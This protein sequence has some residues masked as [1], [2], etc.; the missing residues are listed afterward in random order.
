MINGLT[1]RVT[2]FTVSPKCPNVVLRKKRFSPAVFR[3][4]NYGADD[5]RAR[6]PHTSR[7]RLSHSST[8]DQATAVEGLGRNS[9]TIDD[10]I[11]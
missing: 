5:L 6:P 8:S 2:F 9:A 10:Q 11:P 3:M 4:I 1:K 7:V